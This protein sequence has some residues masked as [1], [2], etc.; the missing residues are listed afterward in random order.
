MLT[1]FKDTHK[2]TYRFALYQIATEASKKVQGRPV[3]LCKSY[4]SPWTL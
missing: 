3:R 2:V 1:G 4:T